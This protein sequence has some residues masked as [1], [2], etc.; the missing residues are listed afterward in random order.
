MDWNF[1]DNPGRRRYQEPSNN[2]GRRLDDLVIRVAEIQGELNQVQERVKAWAETSGETVDKI[3]DL[4]MDA[5]TQGYQLTDA[6]KKLQ[7]TQ[8]SLGT[9]RKEL[10]GLKLTVAKHS[11]SLGIA[12][13]FSTA[14]IGVVVSGIISRIM[15]WL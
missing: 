10:D 8:E 14:A 5:S 3:T 11:M 12:Q 9:L 4:T 15:K 6:L 7:G 2:Q 13:F 1:R